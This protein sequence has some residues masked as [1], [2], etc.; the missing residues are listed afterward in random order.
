[1]KQVDLVYKSIEE[2]IGENKKSVL[3]KFQNSI[4]F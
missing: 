2:K 4:L 3:E 1:M